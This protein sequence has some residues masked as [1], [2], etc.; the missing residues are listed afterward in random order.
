MKKKIPKIIIESREAMQGVVADI[1][2]H[3][4][5]VADLNVQM[6]MEIAIIQR[7]YQG[8]VDKLNKAIQMKEAAAYVWSVKNPQEFGDAKSINF[9][10]AVV[11][12]RT[13][14]PRVDKLRSKQTWSEIALILESLEA[15]NFV[16]ENY[17]S[18][19]DPDLSKE[20][21]IRDRD[22][23]PKKVLEQAG[24]QIVQ[25]EVFYIEPASEIIEGSKKEVV[26]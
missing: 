6:E 24:I 20:A 14:P 25:D 22:I 1:V 15:P 12:F 2:Q 23:I 10:V 4:L 9:K 5:K 7:K 21:L 17:V 19:K 18:Y 11:G 8:E 16:G 26:G 3:R 13:N